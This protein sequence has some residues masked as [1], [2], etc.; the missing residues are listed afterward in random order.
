MLLSAL[1]QACAQVPSTP[2]F[3]I[4]SP[5][6]FSSDQT[7]T[8]ETINQ[9]IN[10][11][12]ANTEQKAFLGIGFHVIDTDQLTSNAVSFGYRVSLVL[13][14]SAAHHAGLQQNDTIIRF[15]G[16]TLD[17]EAESDR[18]L[19]LK[20]YLQ[21]EK[22]VGDE[23]RLA[24]IR[25]TSIIQNSDHQILNTDQVLAQ[26]QHP[27]TQQQ[28]NLSIEHRIEPITVTAT[29]GKQVKGSV[30]DL[31]DPSLFKPQLDLLPSPFGNMSLIQIQ[32]NQLTSEWQDFLYRHAKDELWQG[33]AANACSIDAFRYL[34]LKPHKTL[35]VAEQLSHTVLNASDLTQIAQTWLLTTD[36]PLPPLPDLPNIKDIPTL[37]NL[38]ISRVHAIGNARNAAFSALNAT[39]TAELASLSQGVFDRFKHSFYI[40]QG[41]PHQQAKIHQDNE[42][43]FKLAAKV[44]LYDLLQAARMAQSLN[45]PALIHS[46]KQL[47][48]S[49]PDSGFRTPIWSTS[50]RYG[51]ILIGGM[52]DNEYREPASLIIDL[53]GNDWYIGSQHTHLKH[54]ISIVIDLNGD[55]RYE[56]SKPFSLGGAFMG[57]A[58]LIDHAGHDVYNATEHSL[59]S[60]LFGVGILHDLAGN[61]QYRSQHYS[62]GTAFFGLAALTDHTGNDQYQATLFSQ[63]VGG[64]CG[65]GLIRDL[66]GNDQ[67][68]S[69]K[70][71]PSSYGVSGHFQGVSQGVGIGFRGYARGGIGLLLDQQGSDAY[72]SGNFS[73]GAGYFFGFGV[74]RDWQGNDQYTASRYGLATAAHSAIGAL[75]DDA[76]HDV[77]LGN[78]VALISAAWDLSITAFKDRA[79]D[80][81]YS[82]NAYVFNGGVAAHN[83]YSLMIDQSGNDAYAFEGLR[84]PENYYHGGWSFAFRYDLSGLDHYSLSG[85]NNQ[86]MHSGSFG[87]TADFEADQINHWQQFLQ[88]QTPFTAQ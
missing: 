24:L 26:L 49:L 46:I 18:Q 27:N 65:L 64:T 55:D 70:Q 34:R 76:G 33:R 1:L 59:G 17:S 31:P 14:D 20:N 61:D 73:L 81:H 56:A 86:T 15:D 50:T 85:A 78:H 3:Y 5:E 41:Q 47:T 10:E 16:K 75:I 28:L 42:R 45:D 80:D 82:R 69:L 53:G 68:L 63:G 66:S 60:A 79:G 40:N 57:I 13:P 6:T 25:S 74:L 72:E 19:A 22:S 29:L 39:E 44:N 51:S 4:P 23:I 9:K 43:F 32:H 2:T 48:A 58:L 54:P 36:M 84:V 37:A 83:S 21:D 7:T 38:L 67:Y 12:H 87:F 62:Q 77:Y 8:I 52:S 30:S 88:L 71:K 11:T 35:A